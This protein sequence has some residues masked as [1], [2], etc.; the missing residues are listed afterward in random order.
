MEDFLDRRR[1]A[2][3]ARWNLKDDIVLI[4]AGGPIAIP[5]RADQTYPFRSHSEYFYLADAER[6]GAFLAFDPREGWVHFVPEITPDEAMWTGATGAA[7]AS[8]GDSVPASQLKEWLSKRAG[9]RVALLGNAMPGARSDANLEAELRQQLNEIRWAKDEEELARMRA[10]EKATRAGYEALRPLLRP[11]VTERQAQIEIEAAFFRAGAERTAYDTIVGSGPNSAVLHFPPSSRACRDGELVLVDAGAEVR[12][13]ASDVTRT[14]AVSGTFTAEQND[15]YSVVL[16]AQKAAIERCRVGAEY[17]DIHLAAA[18][19]I[20][21]GLVDFGLLRG[22]PDS[23]VEQ[24]AH[25]LFFPHGIGHMVGLGVR[26]AG[27]YLPGRKPGEQP[28][29][30]YLRIDLPLKEHYVVTI[31]PG[32]YFIPALLN[33]A[34]LRQQHHA[35]VDWKRVDAMMSFGGIRIEDNIHVTAAGPEVMTAAI[36]KEIARERG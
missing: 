11:G 32:I 10:A 25:A 14:Y 1:K 4:G 16:A 22:N 13:Y 5:G 26:D 17:R 28:G 18:H 19:D 15:L 30:R 2:A 33:D 36:P 7:D 27:G 29:L 6:P 20:A 35:T 9:R 12:G 31:E 34:A 21:Q 24:A 3:A 23:L 8:D